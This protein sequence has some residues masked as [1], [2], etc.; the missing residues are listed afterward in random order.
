MAVRTPAHDPGSRCSAL[1]RPPIRQ[2]ARSRLETLAADDVR[3]R[4][5]AVRSRRFGRD[6]PVVDVPLITPARRS[7]SRKQTRVV[8]SVV[9][10][11]A[12][13]SAGHTQGHR[14]TAWAA[15]TRLA[16]RPGKDR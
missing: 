16:G 11:T 4:W 2:R 6:G 5:S 14:L 9:S 1:T 13:P 10:R 15:R 3:A 7:N 12:I 8:L